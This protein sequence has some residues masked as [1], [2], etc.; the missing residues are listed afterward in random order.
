MRSSHPRKRGG[1]RI[2]A[3]LSENSCAGISAALSLIK[4]EAAAQDAVRI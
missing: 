1:L 4:Q 3:N 2:E